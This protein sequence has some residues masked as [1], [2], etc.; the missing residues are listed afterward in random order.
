MPKVAEAGVILKTSF[1]PINP[2]DFILS[3]TVASRR[4]ANLHS[5]ASFQL[6]RVCILTIIKESW[7][8]RVIKMATPQ[9]LNAAVISKMLRALAVGMAITYSIALPRFSLAS[10]P[11][12][13]FGY[14]VVASVLSNEAP[15]SESY[16]VA[17]DSTPLGDRVPLFVNTRH[18]NVVSN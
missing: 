12:L 10:N 7:N 14:T 2:S 17:T 15:G 3:V 5:F 13:P 4:N 8:E 9:W 11:P 18:Q 16:F 1:I 6:N